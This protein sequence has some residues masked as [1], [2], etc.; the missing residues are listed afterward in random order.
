MNFDV[1]PYI[2]L[3]TFHWFGAIFDSSWFFQGKRPAAFPRGSFNSRISL[4]FNKTLINEYLG[5]Q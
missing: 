5:H 2:L 3:K 4:T 1:S